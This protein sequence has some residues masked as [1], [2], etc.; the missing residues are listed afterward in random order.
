MRL[1]L[2]AISVDTTGAATG[3]VDTTVLEDKEKL[4]AN[5]DKNVKSENNKKYKI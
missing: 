1:M 3:N 5:Y 4:D 2:D